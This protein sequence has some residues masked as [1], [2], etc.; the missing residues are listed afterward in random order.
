MA[1]K[2]VKKDFK[3]DDKLGFRRIC[4]NDLKCKDCLLRFDDS[5]EQGNTSKCEAYPEMKPIEVLGGGECEQY[6]ND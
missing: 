4:N 5:K 6:I 3:K 2:N 1:G